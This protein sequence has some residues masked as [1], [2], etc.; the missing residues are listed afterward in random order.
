MA[1]VNL[2]VGRPLCG[3]YHDATKAGGGKEERHRVREASLLQ[4]QRESSIV[5]GAA[6]DRMSVGGSGGG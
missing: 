3:P 2:N 4:L 6:G 1:L 5:E